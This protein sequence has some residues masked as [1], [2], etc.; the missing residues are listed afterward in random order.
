MIGNDEATIDTERLAAP[1]P[2]CHDCGERHLAEDR[3]RA[4]GADDILP[5]GPPRLAEILAE[6]KPSDG[7]VG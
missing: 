4:I 7:A 3:C 5:T 1:W 6:L 2:V